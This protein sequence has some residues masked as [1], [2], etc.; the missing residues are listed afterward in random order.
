MVLIRFIMVEKV[1]FGVAAA[2]DMDSLLPQSLGAAAALKKVNDLESFLISAAKTSIDSV[3]N[4]DSAGWLLQGEHYKN[5]QPLIDSIKTYVE[6]PTHGVT[7]VYVTGHSL[8]AGMASWYMTDKVAGGAYLESKNIHVF[9]ASFAAPG[10]VTTSTETRELHK[11]SSYYR[12]EVAKDP[13]ADAGQIADN[14]ADHIPTIKVY[15]PGQQINVV[16]T[17]D[18]TAYAT[19]T[20]NIEFLVNAIDKL[21]PMDD[22]NDVVSLLSGS[23]FIDDKEFLQKNTNI[24]TVNKDGYFDPVIMTALDDLTVVGDGGPVGTVSTGD[25]GAIVPETFGHA[26]KYTENDVIVGTVGNDALSGDGGGSVFGTNDVFYLGSGWD[27]VYGDRSADDD[28]GLDTVVYKFSDTLIA[29]GQINGMSIVGAQSRQ[30]RNDKVEHENDLAKVNIDGSPDNLTDIEQFHFID[31][32]SNTTNLLVG[33]KGNDVIKAMYGNDYLAGGAGNDTLDGGVGNDRIHGGAGADT[34]DYA[35][36]NGADAAVSIENWSVKVVTPTDVDYLYSVENLHFEGGTSSTK[37]ALSLTDSQLLKMYA[38]SLALHKDDYI[39]TKIEAFLDHAVLFE[40]HGVID[41]PIAY[42]KNV[43]SAGSSIW[44]D[45]G[46]FGFNDE[47][48]IGFNLN[49]PKVISGLL[50]SGESYY[51]DFIN[52]EIAD[53][54]DQGEYLRTNNDNDVISFNMQDVQDQYGSAVYGR[55]V[56]SSEG[57]ILQYHFFYLENDWRQDVGIAGLHEADWEFMQIKL[58]E[59]FLPISFEAS[60]HIGYAQVR[61][62]FDSDV[63]HIGNHVVTYGTSGG[64][65]TYFTKGETYFTEYNG[66]DKRFDDKWLL[67]E[68]ISGASSYKDGWGKDISLDGKERMAYDLVEIK[69]DDFVDKWLDM[70]VAWGKDYT[71]FPISNPPVSPPKNSDG[72]WSDAEDWLSN[73]IDASTGLNN[74]VDSSS[75]DKEALKSDDIKLAGL[76]DGQMDAGFLFDDTP[77]APLGHFDLV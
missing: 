69:D 34:A 30:D 41:K 25:L 60:T 4:T 29:K 2:V 56:N 37:S 5:F 52:R 39:P 20:P 36:V 31:T 77:L 59:D 61:G 11:N 71:A 63:N 53:H 72:R 9:G 13:V 64:H 67:P 74:L 10:I 66:T 8:G 48:V 18:I 51:V 21:H 55:V 22:Y 68:D 62:A 24:F 3:P 42:G 75:Y 46:I 12:I 54:K 14:S 15:E 38:P 19:V 65:G 40:E 43:G 23:G 50:K 49:D 32:A 76:E 58:G 27:T 1:G 73:N 33:G 45:D 70:N 7:K 57:K 17:D 26:E 47:E 16:T 35:A 6:D 28:G 44:E